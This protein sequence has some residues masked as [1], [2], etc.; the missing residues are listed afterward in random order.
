MPTIAFILLLLA[1]GM[2][3]IYLIR[4]S[5]EGD[6]ISHF[7]LLGA[8]VL[9]LATIVHRSVAINFVAIT[10]TYESLIF[11]SAMIAA[12][13]FVYRAQKRFR[14]I[15]FVT[16]GAT[17]VA[18]AL[19]SLTSSP[20]AASSIQPPI[21]ALQSYWLV[22][23]VTLSFIG[24]AFFTIAFV[25]SIVYLA[26]RNPERRSNIDRII[27]T[28]IGIGYPIFTTGALVFGAIWAKNAWGSYWSWDPKETWSLITWLTYTAYLHLRL[29]GKTRGKISAIASIA[30]YL[31]MLFT[32]F[33][34]NYLLSSLH[35]Y[36]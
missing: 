4:R 31:F 14:K 33:G 11:F 10:N 17:V 28:S 34:V 23:H 20:I 26:S 16:F 6:P 27:Y 29:I 21:P 1:A 19:L 5:A 12:L 9:L 36:G 24:E 25:A 2:Q 22:A 7:F 3:I 32:F 18:L 13:L 30:G 15:P 35:S 8:A